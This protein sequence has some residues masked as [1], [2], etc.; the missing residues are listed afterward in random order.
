[1]PLL[2]IRTWYA[3]FTYS[4][5]SDTMSSFA[6]MYD[7]LDESQKQEYGREYFTELDKRNFLRLFI[8]W[9]PINVTNDLVHAT[10]ATCPRDQ[11]VTGM[12]LKVRTMA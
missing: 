11:Y 9:D 8:P 1:M 3:L 4:M 6:K 5:L 2:I 7:T 10:T 12:D